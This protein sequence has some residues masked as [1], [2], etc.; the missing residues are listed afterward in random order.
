MSNQQSQQSEFDAK[1][2]TGTEIC[3]QLGL[4]RGA[5]FTAKKR[6]ILPQPVVVLGSKTH[7]WIRDEVKDNLDKWEFSLKARRKELI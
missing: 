2:I 1:Y 4:S 7:L 6:G 5:L 3:A